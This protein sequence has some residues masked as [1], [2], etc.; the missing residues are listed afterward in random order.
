MNEYAPDKHKQPAV[1]L[2]PE[3]ISGVM[4]LGLSLSSPISGSVDRGTAARTQD[5]GLELNPLVRFENQ[6][7]SNWLPNAL[8]EKIDETMALYHHMRAQGHLTIQ[9]YSAKQLAGMYARG[10]IHWCEA[11]LNEKKID[12]ITFP[13]VPD[14]N[15]VAD[16]VGGPVIF[17]GSFFDKDQVSVLQGN[18]RTAAVLFRGQEHNESLYVLR[19]R[20][21]TYSQ[22][23]IGAT[24]SE[25]FRAP[26]VPLKYSFSSSFGASHG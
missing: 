17:V 21:S 2:S 18:H 10:R 11:Q 12:S 13:L 5:R 20:A 25:G 26:K 7:V 16:N 3:I 1:D 15:L 9:A 19:F 22:Q 24:P 8:P 23:L 6:I 4:P 14:F